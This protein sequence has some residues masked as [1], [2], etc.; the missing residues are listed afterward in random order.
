VG[1]P[2]PLA[3]LYPY[4][5][6]DGATGAHGSLRH[7]RH[8]PYAGAVPPI[9]HLS[10]PARDLETTRRFYVGTLGCAGGRRHTG[11]LD[12]WFH[13]MQLTFH[14]VPDLV[15]S[16]DDAGVRHFGVTLPMEE[17]DQLIARLEAVPVRWVSR[18]RTDGAG[19]TQE[20]RKAKL[21][22]PDGHVIEVKAYAD[23]VAALEI[24]PGDGGTPAG[25]AVRRRRRRRR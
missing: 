3:P 13:G 22:D 6:Q 23:P 21:A 15:V 20:Q 9:L 8:R 12:V 18:V 24:P 17:L 2:S 4:G 19:T 5:Y 25:A 10:L 16:P 11:W 7:R 1:S 14:Q